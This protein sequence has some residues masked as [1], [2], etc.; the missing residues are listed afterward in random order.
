MN[1]NHT[2]GL[3]WTVKVCRLSQYSSNV[4]IKSCS[5]RLWQLGIF[6]M[7]NHSSVV[8]VRLSGVCKLWIMPISRLLTGLMPPLRWDWSMYPGILKRF[9]DKWVGS[10]YMCNYFNNNGYIYYY[11]W[12]EQYGSR[13][14]YFC[15]CLYKLQHLCGH[16][17]GTYSVLIIQSAEYGLLWKQ[18]AC[19]TLTRTYIIYWCC[20]R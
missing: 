12:R 1:I 13:L 20:T 19:I 4:D 7:S 10:H 9:R 16:K 11:D 2:R 5:D 15:L 3:D 6:C 14:F 18:T 8:I 17:S